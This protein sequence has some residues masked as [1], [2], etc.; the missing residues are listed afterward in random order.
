VKILQRSWEVK[1]WA[2]EEPGRLEKKTSKTIGNSQ[3]KNEKT[4][5]NARAKKTTVRAWVIDDSSGQGEEYKLN[6]EVVK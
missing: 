4:K 2:Q 1:V 6:K 3:P 5:Q